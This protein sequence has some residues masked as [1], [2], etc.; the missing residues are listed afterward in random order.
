MRRSKVKDMNVQVG[1]ESRQNSMKSLPADAGG[2]SLL[3]DKHPIK[4]YP[5]EYEETDQHED[6]IHKNRD[7]RPEPKKREKKPHPDSTPTNNRH[8][9]RS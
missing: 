3:G 5:S 6:L 2:N 9:D 1:I 7:R 8:P 4:E